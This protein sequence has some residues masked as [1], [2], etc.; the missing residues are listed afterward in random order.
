MF[1]L[2]SIEYEYALELSWKAI[3]AIARVHDGMGNDLDPNWHHQEVSTRNTGLSRYSYAGVLA[4]L[5]LSSLDSS[6][7]SWKP[8]FILAPFF[9]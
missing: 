2:L 1:N 5:G 9:Y 6:S 8:P 7:A 3:L 4:L